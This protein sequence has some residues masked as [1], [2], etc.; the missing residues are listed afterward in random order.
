MKVWVAG[1]SGMLGQAVMS[2]LKEQECVGSDRD[3][4][5]VTE[6]GQMADWVSM[7]GVTHLVNCTGF[8]KVDA[9]E[10]YPGLAHAVNAQAVESMGRLGVKVI[11][12]ST[13]Y[14]FDGNSSQPYVETDRAAPLNVYGMSK[15]RGEQRLLKVAP[16]S[17]V[18]RSA[19]MY[20]AGEHFVRA[21]IEQMQMRES[22]RVVVDHVGCP[23]S[24]EDVAQAVLQLLDRSGVW[25]V[26]NEG[27]A[28]RLEWVEAIRDEMG[29]RGMDLVCQRV[30]P[31]RSSEFVSLAH[32]PKYSALSI[33]KLK[34]AGIVMRG[35]KEALESYMEQEVACLIP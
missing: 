14:I 24:A 2:A 17:C 30:D 35:W 6:V 13:D 10:K 33:E 12:F 4:V 15:L 25:N 31:A 28:T 32:R 21:M 20:G 5:D 3:D 34:G 7:H 23:T 16:D 11:H 18:I 26:V 22:V 8:T 27:C 29:K 19:W 1:A 9:A